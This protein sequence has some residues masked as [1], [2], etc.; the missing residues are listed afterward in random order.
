M[1][2]K[3]KVVSDQQMVKKIVPLLGDTRFIFATDP[4]TKTRERIRCP[5]LNADGTAWKGNGKRCGKQIC[6]T[7]DNR[8]CGHMEEDASSLPSKGGRMKKQQV[9]LVVIEK[10]QPEMV[11]TA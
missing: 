4:E 10:R 7:S 8:D 9:S 2:K 11:A 3:A 6:I 1:S 5:K